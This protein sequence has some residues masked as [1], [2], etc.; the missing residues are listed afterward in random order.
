[1]NDPVPDE[2]VADDDLDGPQDGHDG[3]WEAAR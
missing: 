1:M 2:P 3:T